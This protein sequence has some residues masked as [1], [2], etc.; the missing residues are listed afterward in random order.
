MDSS[1]QSGRPADPPLDKRLLLLIAVLLIPFAFQIFNNAGTNT[2]KFSMKD[3]L[4]TWTDPAGAKGN[5]VRFWT[6]KT[7]SKTPTVLGEAQAFYY[8][9]EMSKMLGVKKVQSLV[10]LEGPD[11]FGYTIEM[12]PLTSPPMHLS[13]ADKGHDH[14]TLRLIKDSDLE[15]A[16]GNKAFTPEKTIELVRTKENDSP[17]IKK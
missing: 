8:N 7:G 11:H 12:A 1:K 10:S 2:N 6:E 13:L 16:L 9:G 4:G 14:L 15:A 5:Y 17:P 3:A